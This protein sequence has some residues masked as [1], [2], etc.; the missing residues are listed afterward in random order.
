MG[1][2]G[3]AAGLARTVGPKCIIVP[4]HDR[5]LVIGATGGI[6]AA[7]ALEL[8][9]R[10]RTVHALVRS[11]ERARARLGTAER[12]RVFTGDVEDYASLSR[13]SEG[14]TA[15][16]HAARFPLHQ[17]YPRMET[18]LKLVIAAAE[19]RHARL[20]FPSNV[21]D[22]G[23]QTHFPLDETAPEIPCS[24]IG[25]LQ[26]RLEHDLER[27]S[28]K[29]R[30]RTLLIRSGHLFGPTVRN[31]L[32]DPLFGHAAAGRPMRSLV[33]P[34]AAHEWAYAPDLARAIADLLER[35]EQLE[36]YERVHV[37]GHVARPHRDF[38]RQIATLAGRPRLPVLGRSWLAMRLA[39]LVSPSLRELRELRYVFEVLVSLE[40]RRLPVLVPD[41]RRT[42]LEEAIAS[43]LS[44]YR[45]SDSVSTQDPS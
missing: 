11:D 22:F 17:S 5:V 40:S 19:A 16:V 38:C 41:H 24:S 37:P 35:D 12:L 10:E 23:A 15:I 45:R 44:S 8:L 36:P 20:V 1:G 18:S 2:T 25:K 21:Y 3:G 39:S 29:A 43:T 13:A 34:G 31:R 28:E 6:G 32:V 33:R 14:C 27:A 4:M 42:P 9:A 26:V 30:I 7:V